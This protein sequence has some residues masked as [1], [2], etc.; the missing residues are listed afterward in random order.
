MAHARE[1]FIPRPT[2]VK[3]PLDLADVS[4]LKSFS[5]IV[6]LENFAHFD[7]R[8]EIDLPEELCVLFNQYS[9]LVG[10]MS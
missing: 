3:T 2:K 6:S 7:T 4:A 9:R 1:A 8:V 10:L 5:G